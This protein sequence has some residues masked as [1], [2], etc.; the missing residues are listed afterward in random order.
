LLLSVDADHGHGS[1]SLFQ[2]K[3][4]VPIFLAVSI[5]M[6]NQFFRES[7]PILYYL[8][9]YLCEGRIQQS[10]GRSAGCYDRLHKTWCSV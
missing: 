8:K 9:R 3:Y 10:F 4:R 6:F 1:E 7:T 2:A 5:A